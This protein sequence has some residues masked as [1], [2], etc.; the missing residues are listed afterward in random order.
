MFVETVNL[1]VL[2]MNALYIPYVEPQ[3]FA[4]MRKTMESV[5]ELI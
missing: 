3:Q 5:N 4:L 2:R 1:I